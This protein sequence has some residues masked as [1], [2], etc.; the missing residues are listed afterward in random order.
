MTPSEKDPWNFGDEIIPT[1]KFAIYS[2]IWYNFPKSRL[3]R[4][5]CLTGYREKYQ[6]WTSQLC[7][8]MLVEKKLK[9]KLLFKSFGNP[10]IKSLSWHPLVAKIL[11]L[12]IFRLQI[13]RITICTTKA[14]FTIAA[15]NSLELSLTLSKAFCWSVLFF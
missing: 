14:K 1:Q 2:Q 9:T 6:I 15:K 7:S 11:G 3:F 5:H 13:F 8:S 10:Q 12:Q 4:R